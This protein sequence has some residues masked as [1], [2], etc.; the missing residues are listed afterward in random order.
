MSLRLACGSVGPGDLSW[1]DKWKRSIIRPHGETL[2]PRREGLGVCRKRRETRDSEGGALKQGTVRGPPR[3][4]G[5]EHVRGRGVKGER[6]TERDKE[7][8][9]QAVSSAQNLA[10]GLI[11]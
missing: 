7:N 10:W 11:P 8:L 5:R 4:R 3:G 2:G 9:K 6:E 1:A